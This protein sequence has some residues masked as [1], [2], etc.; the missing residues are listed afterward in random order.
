[1]NPTPHTKLLL[2]VTSPV[3]WVFYQGLVGHLRASG[4]HPILLSSPGPK[5]QSTAEQEGVAQAAVPMEREIAIRKD[6]V[7]LYRLWRTI[8]RIRPEMV[9]ASTPKAGLLVGVAAWLCGVPCRIY[10]LHGLRMETATGGKRIV[11]T[12]AERIAAACSHQVL[13]LSPSL[14]ERAINLNL[15][16]RRK[17]V[18]LEKGSSGVDLKRFAPADR[19]A[20]RTVELLRQL[21]I[22]KDVP[23]VGFVGRFVKDKGIR[24]LVEAFEIL[25][26][27]FPDLRLLLLGDFEDGDPVEPETRHYIESTQEI[28]RPGFVADTA[29]YYGLMDVLAFPTYRE[30]FGQV[31]LEAQASGVPVVTTNTT[32]SIDSVID[33]VTGLLTPVGD[34]RALAEALGKLLADDK[35]RS[36]MAR[37]G[38]A[39]M[40]RD[41]RPEAIW[42]AQVRLY[43][44]LL[45]ERIPESR[46][47]ARQRIAKRAFD[48]CL[49]LLALV[50][51][52]PVLVLVAILVR[53]LLGGPVLFRQVR[54]GLNGRPFTIF[55]FRTMNDDR[56][57]RGEPLPDAS[58]LTRFGRFLRS[59]SLD[60][61]PELINVMRGDM[62][63]VGPRPLLC[64]YLDRYTPE[65]KRR[66][67]VKPGITGW[68][69][70]NGRNAID[71]DQKFALDL[72]YV[73]HQSFGLDC[74]ILARTVWQVLKR[75]GIAQPGHVTMPEFFRTRSEPR[76][77]VSKKSRDSVATC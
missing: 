73:D 63:L 41:F 6:I 61:L 8:R 56:D 49:S 17:T 12:W 29:P 42:D 74:R 43:R 71:W 35:L 11:L 72:W 25:R 57:G 69:Q 10:S 46:R 1:M 24:Q 34:S 68:V 32:G 59:T 77:E 28:I 19:R 9:D 7:S 65:Q 58:R 54:P 37:D 22:P 36:R 21:G 27:Q 30:G 62:S 52:S 33:G 48:I 16:A 50:L 47:K 13:C 23:V 66:H 2:A 53:L 15:V 44:E 75:E 38:R 39:W 51:L 55:K 70:V 18:V 3:S 67:E 45:S 26:R 40:E 14:R 20:A 31:S 5:L 76:T 64:Q 4:F 60:E